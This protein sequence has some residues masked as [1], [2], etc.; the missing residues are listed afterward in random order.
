MNQHCV[1]YVDICE[2]VGGS[3][4]ETLLDIVFVLVGT[5]ERELHAILR[6][7]DVL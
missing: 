5:R 4:Q 7:I 6:G 3:R 1:N 2:V